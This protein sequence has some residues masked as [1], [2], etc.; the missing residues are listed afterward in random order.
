MLFEYTTMKSTLT[1]FYST[2]LHNILDNC[3]SSVMD[4]LQMF[5]EPMKRDVQ[6]FGIA[7]ERVDRVCKQH[8]ASA[9]TKVI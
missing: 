2:Q 6:D 4:A 1:S 7:P 8:L 9:N 5:M 3:H